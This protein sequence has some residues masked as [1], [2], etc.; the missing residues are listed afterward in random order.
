MEVLKA[1]KF[2]LKPKPR[3]EQL[4]AQYAGACRVVWNLCLEQRQ[5]VYSAR[6]KTVWYNTQ[7]KEITALRAEYDWLGAVPSQMLQQTVRDLDRAYVNFFE[8][9]AE[10]PVYKKKGMRDS[11]RFPQGFRLDGNRVLLPKAGWLRFFKSREVEGEIRHVTVSRHGSHWH[12]S[13][14]C[15]EEVSEPEHRSGEI[16]IDMGVAKLCAM[17]DGTVIE[18]PCV[19]KQWKGKLARA[20]RNLARKVKFSANWK[21]QKRRI[22]DVHARIADI[23]RNYIH[24]ETTKIAE[25][26]G[27]VVVEDLRVKN[28]TRSARGTVD[29][30]GRNVRQKAGLNRSILDAAWG[31]FR[32]QLEYKLTWNGGILIVVPPQRTSQTCRMCGCVSAAN[33]RTQARFECTACGHTEDADINAAKNILAAGLAVIACGGTALAA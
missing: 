26:Q 31:E 16:G 4:F 29:D 17:S 12:V 9:R 1:Y 27:L 32:R 14:T 8:K 3:H 20:Q 6:R 10:R 21:K 28:M 7:A 33:R 30:P 25:S 19:L 18:N 22:S 11:F 15:K 23:R 5:E 13:F 24:N 2:R